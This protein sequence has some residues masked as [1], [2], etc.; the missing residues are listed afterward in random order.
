LFYSTIDSG[1]IQSVSD[2]SAASSISYVPQVGLNLTTN[3]LENG[4]SSADGIWRF[5]VVGRYIKL[6]FDSG[7]QS[8]VKVLVMLAKI[9]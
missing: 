7:N 1:E 5:G 3:V 6:V 8:T 4:N 9:S 2:G